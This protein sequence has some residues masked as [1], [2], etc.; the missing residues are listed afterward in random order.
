VKAS[1]NQVK[2]GH[3]SLGK[4]FGS[5]TLSG[6]GQ[7]VIPGAARRELGLEAGTRLLVFESEGRAGTGLL[8]MPAETVADF[9]REASSRFAELER[10]I[11]E[12]GEEYREQ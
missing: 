8:L 11:N 2:H 4:C 10:M 7:V 6:R 1:E 3:R 12:E 5:T 9:V